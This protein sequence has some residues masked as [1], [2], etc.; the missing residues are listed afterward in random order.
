[1]T[2]TYVTPADV[3]IS[4]SWQD[5]KS[6]NPPSKEPGTDFNTPY[7][8]DI[9]M[10]E[11]GVIVITDNDNGGAEGRRL[12]LIMDNGEVIDYLHLS[13]IMGKWNQ[14]VKKGQ[15]GIALS[16]ASGNGSD[17][18]YG[19]HVHVT[20]RATTGMPYA[21]AIDFMLAVG[22]NPSGGGGSP[23]ILKEDDEMLAINIVDT[24]RKRSYKCAIGEGIFRHFIASD[25]PEWVKNVMR[26]NDDWQDVD[27]ITQLPV[28]LR[29]Y[30]C[31]LNIYDFVNN[32]FAVHD[33]LTGT[34]KP[35]N[36]WSAVNE[37]RAKQH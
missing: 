26:I 18:Y 10:A 3:S 4:S 5:H 1:M 34:V 12:E 20:R 27:L 9:R 13:K 32:D 2:G 30:G 28:L 24:Q 37:L 6:R 36:M 19:P 35:G 25:N 7:G 15:T 23:F 29:T 8:T 22:G 14:R 17:W 21:S 33:P 16:G 31:D 11:S